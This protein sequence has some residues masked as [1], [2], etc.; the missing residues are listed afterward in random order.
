MNTCPATAAVIYTTPQAAYTA[1]R[2]V[3]HRKSSTRHA[4]PS[5]GALGAYRCAACKGWHVGWK[6]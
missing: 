5:P 1:V 2:C 6:H 3:C 4:K